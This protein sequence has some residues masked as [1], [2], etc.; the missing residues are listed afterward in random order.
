MSREELCELMN[1]PGYHW[2]VSHPQAHLPEAVAG[3]LVR[4]YNTP[5]CRLENKLRDMGW[6]KI[7]SFQTAH[8]VELKGGTE[9]VGVGVQEEPALVP[10]RG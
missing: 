2:L 3:G 8:R 4:R 7:D 5:H 9:G 1:E 6:G 10:L